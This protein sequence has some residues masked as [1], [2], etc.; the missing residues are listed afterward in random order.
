MGGESRA[1]PRLWRR[2]PVG[3]RSGDG[4][5]GVYTDGNREDDLRNLVEF[6]DRVD[7]EV[8]VVHGYKLARADNAT[9]KV[10]GRFCHPFVSVPFG[11]SI[12]DIDCDCRLIAP[13][14]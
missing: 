2:A 8:D 4:R 6:I 9:P 11:L 14:P 12:R 7:Y 10:T 5:A 13:C 1:K 3:I